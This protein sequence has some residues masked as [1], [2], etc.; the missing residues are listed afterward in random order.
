M[1]GTIPW[2]FSS[3]AIKAVERAAGLIVNEVRRQFKDPAI[4]NYSEGAG[5]CQRGEH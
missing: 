5:L 4:M 1:G 3:I 2:L